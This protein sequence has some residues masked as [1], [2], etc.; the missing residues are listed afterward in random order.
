MLLHRYPRAWVA[1]KLASQRSSKEVRET[2][3]GPEP[4]TVHLLLWGALPSEA[5]RLKVSRAQARPA[6]GIAGLEA[7]N[8]MDT[9]HCGT[10]KGWCGCTGEWG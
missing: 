7:G 10:A 9:V 8:R 3:V 2:P 4:T 1:A 5:I 6:E